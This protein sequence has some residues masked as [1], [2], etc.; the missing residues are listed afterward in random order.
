MPELSD[1]FAERYAI[2][3]AFNKLD[4]V[5]AYAAAHPKNSRQASLLPVRES[6]DFAERA[7]LL[8]A[9]PEV[10]ARITFLEGQINAGRAR[11]SELIAENNGLATPQQKRGHASMHRLNEPKRGIDDII[12]YAGR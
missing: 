9:Q 1:S 5:A 6:E 3:R 8:E 11:L 4:P 2:A 10:A 7:A 12:W